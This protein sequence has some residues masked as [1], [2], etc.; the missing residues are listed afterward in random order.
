M[1]EGQGA[2]ARLMFD[3]TAAVATGQRQMHNPAS[4][5]CPQCTSESGIL[6]DPLYTPYTSTLKIGF[7]LFY[8]TPVCTL[9]H[10]CKNCLLISTLE[11]VSFCFYKQKHF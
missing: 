10:Y 3:Q 8:F 4:K 9:D 5:I 1:V 6:W 2:A 11:L 7:P